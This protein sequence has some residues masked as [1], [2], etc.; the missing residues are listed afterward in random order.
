MHAIE[1]NG[2]LYTAHATCTHSVHFICENEEF[3]IAER[4]SVNSIR[5]HRMRQRQRVETSYLLRTTLSN[6][7]QSFRSGLTLSSQYVCHLFHVSEQWT[8]NSTANRMFDD[9]WNDAAALDWINA[10]VFLCKKKQVIR[11]T[12]VRAQIPR[13]TMERDACHRQREGG[14]EKWTNK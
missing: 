2:L 3:C 10:C 12:N 13:R 5:S 4:H 14:R 8:L 11:A 7:F 9:D 6:N 1:R